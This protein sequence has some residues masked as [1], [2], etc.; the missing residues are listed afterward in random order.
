MREEN[1]AVGEVLVQEEGEILQ[2]QEEGGT[3]EM[4]EGGDAAKKSIWDRLGGK[5]G[6]DESKEKIA[7]RPVSKPTSRVS[8]LEVLLMEDTLTDVCHLSP[9]QEEGSSGGW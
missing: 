5:A 3:A 9:V 4:E 2:V 1:E 6:D 7:S 8:Y